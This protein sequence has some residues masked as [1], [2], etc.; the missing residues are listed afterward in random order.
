MK[1]FK[2]VVHGVEYG[3]E[4]KKKWTKCGVLM[5]NEEG[6]LSIKLDYIPVEFN[7]W[8]SV[9]D[10]K[11]KDPARNAENYGVRPESDDPNDP[12]F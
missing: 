7:G 12:P 4:G 6:R 1:T 8:L 5:E 3:S 11:P 2:D 9:F 10:Q